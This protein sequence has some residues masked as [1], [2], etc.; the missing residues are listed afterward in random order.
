MG[1]RHVFVDSASAL[2]AILSVIAL[3]VFDDS[4]SAS[5]AI[6]SV[7]AVA[8]VAVRSGEDVVHVGHR[9]VRNVRFQ[10][11]VPRVDKLRDNLQHNDKRRM[12][13]ELQ[14]LLLFL[15][16]SQYQ[17]YFT[18]RTIGTLLEYLTKRMIPPGPRTI[19]PPQ[20]GS[21][22]ARTP[23]HLFLSSLFQTLPACTTSSTVACHGTATAPNEKVSGGGKTA[24]GGGGAVVTAM[25]M[26]LAMCLP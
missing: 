26:A 4:A 25:A 17:W 14:S 7:I 12:P 20:P 23:P 24:I 16:F 3:A 2:A 1:L 9:A 11:Y 21:S 13:R 15:S 10:G 5:A 22:F 18:I 8:V 6:L 19:L